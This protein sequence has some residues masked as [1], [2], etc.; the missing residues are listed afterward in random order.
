MVSCVRHS[1]S[2]VQRLRVY[3]ELNALWSGDVDDDGDVFLIAAYTCRTWRYRYSYTDA[4]IPTEGWMEVDAG[5]YYNAGRLD[6]GA[7][8]DRVDT[9]LAPRQGIQSNQ[10]ASPVNPENG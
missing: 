1:C 5:C 9:A 8:A 10:T 2:C 6:F 4:E 7:A 3:A